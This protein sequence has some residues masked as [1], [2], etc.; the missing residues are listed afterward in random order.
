M[1]DGLL[2]SI[3][4]YLDAVPRPATR[5]EEIGPFTLFVNEGIGWRY[6]ARPT[7]G[8]GRF[9][10]SDVQIVLDRQ[11]ELD[12]PLEFEWLVDVTPDVGPATE[13]AG[14]RVVE[15]PLMHLP[16]GDF[17]P[18]TAPDGALV[19]LVGSGDDL[20]TITAVAMVS[21]DSP[22]TGVSPIGTESLAGR[23]GRLV[24]GRLEFARDRI[25]RELTITAVA[26]VEGSPVASGSHQPMNGLTEIVGVACLPAFRRR[27]LGAAVTS[28]LARDAFQRQVETVFLSA[29]DESVARIYGRLG[30]RTIGRVGA[31]APP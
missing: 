11:R 28:T 22:G 31:A 17:R 13:S 25:A 10:S 24:A 19:R 20:A 8:A 5:V 30:F 29:D 7:V 16:V 26:F 21:F 6:Y 18:R 1:H 23:A 2:S 15:R 14:L 4:G 3:D 12:Q 27:G 9:T